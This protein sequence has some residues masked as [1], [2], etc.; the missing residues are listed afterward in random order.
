M[1]SPPVPRMAPCLAAA[2]CGL[3]RPAKA[4]STRQGSVQGAY[5]PA[6]G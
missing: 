4:A 3:T 2:S 5:V 6:T 1:S